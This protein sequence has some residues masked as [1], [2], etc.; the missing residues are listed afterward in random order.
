MSSKIA[1]NLLT[2]NVADENICDIIWRNVSF[3]DV[4]EVF[5]FPSERV[6]NEYLQVLQNDKLEKFASLLGPSSIIDKLLNT[7]LDDYVVKG[8]INNPSVTKDQL[9]LIGQQYKKYQSLALDRIAIKDEE[10]KLIESGEYKYIKDHELIISLEKA[11]L[12]KLLDHPNLEERNNMIK[13]VLLN[14]SKLAKDVFLAILGSADND[15]FGYIDSFIAQYLV[16]NLNDKEVETHLGLVSSK[17]ISRRVSKGALAKLY[18][19]GYNFYLNKNYSN[20][21]LNKTSK[22]MLDTLALAG[23]APQTIATLVLST[24]VDLTAEEFAIRLA[25]APTALIANFIKGGTGR[26]PQKMEISSLLSLFDL[27][28]RNEL[29]TEIGEFSSIEDYPW[30]NEL[31]FSLPKGFLQNNHPSFAVEVMQFLKDELGDRYNAWEFFLIVSEEWE[32]DFHTL[33]AAANN[34]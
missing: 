25:N 27:T 16:D 8:L 18:N 15:Y 17:N 26:K 2:V 24:N 6:I 12:L 34:V 33:V 5:N 22:S 19:A 21:D 32:D 7:K 30:A 20:V 10:R 23:E 3:D 4:N 13:I 28:K 9:N 31:A 29:A 11:D 14:N 1:K